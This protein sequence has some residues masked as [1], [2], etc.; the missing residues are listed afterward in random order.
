MARGGAAPRVRI[1]AGRI[2]LARSRFASR[3]LPD[4]EAMQPMEL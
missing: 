3:A 4:P 1:E 2:S